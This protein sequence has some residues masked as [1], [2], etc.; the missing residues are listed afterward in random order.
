VNVKEIKEA[1]LAAGLRT[2]MA[3]PVAFCTDVLRVKPLP[4]QEDFMRAVAA[5]KR[6]VG[7]Q[8]F[9]IKSAVGVGK[10]F[11][12][13]ALVIWNTACFPDAKTACTAPTSNQLRGV[14]WPE[15][16]KL[17]RGIPSEFQTW[18]PLEWQ[19]E[20][21]VC[22]DN[23]AM[24]R[25][26]DEYNPEALQGIH[27]RNVMLVADEASAVPDSIFMAAQG[28]MSEDNAV[29]I[30]IGN[31]TRSSGYFFNCFGVNSAAWN[32][33][34]ITAFDSSRV[35]SKFIEDMATEHGRESFEY[36]VRIMGEFALEQSGIVIPISWVQEAMQRQVDPDGDYVVWGV[37]VS[38]GRD[39]SAL[40]RRCGNTLLGITSYSGLSVM[41]QVSRVAD[42]YG[43][44]PEPRRPAEICVDAIGMGAPFAERLAEVLRSE[45]VA[46]RRVNVSRRDCSERFVSLRVELWDRGRRWFESALV[47][48][49]SD[50]TVLA[51]QL[52]SVEWE[53]SDSKGK[54]QL[55]DK[56]AGGSSPEQADAFLLTFA[57]IRREKNSFT[58]ERNKRRIELETRGIGSAS[59]L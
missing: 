14:L 42:A 46:I 57:G 32:T 15:I 31:P 45:P 55:V 27:A 22:R 56:A 49:P 54:W 43:D 5:G 21:L 37:D 3:D 48:V 26:A 18:F 52:S 39:K 17:L 12:V 4:W 13:A 24:A 51:A 23:F 28:V 40:A 8:R 58:K 34:T 20:R 33:R 11:A 50:S 36:R 35:S 47:S 16:A 29:T 10:T 6:G 19:T 41:Q 44:T 38:D 7:L 53:V 25:T 30:L 59:Y 9:A 1:G 2:W